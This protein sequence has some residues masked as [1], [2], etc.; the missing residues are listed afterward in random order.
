[1]FYSNF[2][3]T[4][5]GY[6][7]CFVLFMVIIMC[8]YSDEKIFVCYKCTYS[9]GAFLWLKNEILFSVNAYAF[10]PMILF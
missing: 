1:M 6:I 7:F 10:I 8:I 2:G 9:Y 5:S 3:Y 4:C